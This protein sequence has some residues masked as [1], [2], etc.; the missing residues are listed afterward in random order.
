MTSFKYSRYTCDTVDQVM[1]NFSIISE[2][3]YPIGLAP[4]LMPRSKS[5]KSRRHAINSLTSIHTDSLEHKAFPC[6]QVKVVLP[7]IN[8]T[9]CFL[10]IFGTSVYIVISCLSLE[11]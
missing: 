9:Y 10:I 11:A 2:A 6:H 5:D 1:V 7:T 4:N 8:F 3:E